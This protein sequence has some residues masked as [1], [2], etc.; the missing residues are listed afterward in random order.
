[1]KQPLNPNASSAESVQST[2]DSADYQIQ[3]VSL[4]R[5]ASEEQM[6]DKS[7][8]EDDFTKITSM[9]LPDMSKLAELLKQQRQQLE[10]AVADLVP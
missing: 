7:V 6:L 2:A 5:Q 8:F 4:T 9:S 10:S 1:M 3:T